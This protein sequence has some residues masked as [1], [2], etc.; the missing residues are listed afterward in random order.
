MKKLKRY[1]Q[2]T[3]AAKA[4]MDV[5]TAR[6]YIK[7]KMLPSDSRKA[8]H[9]EQP[10]IFAGHWDEIARMLEASP[11]LQSHTIMNYLVRKYPDR[12]K[13]SQ[14]R[15]LQ[16]HLHDWR[17]EYGASQAV[18]FRQDILPGKQ[19]QSDYTCMNALNIRINGQ[20]FKHLLFHFMLP[21]SRWESVYLCFSE[22]FETLTLGYEKAVW[23]LG[24]TAPEHRTDNLTAATHAYGGHREFTARW[25]EFMDH[26]SVMP[27]TNNIGVSHE[28]GSIEKSHDTLKNAIEQELMLRD[29]ADFVTQKDYMTFI[30]KIVA[31]RNLQRQDRLLAEMDYLIELPD[32]KWHSPT[33]MR[34][35]VSSGSIVQV[36]DVPY[37]VP[38]RLI[39]YT[40]KAYIYPDEIILFYGNKKIQTMPRARHHLDGI[41]YRHLID[42]LVRKPAAFANYQYHEALFPRLCFRKAYD[43]LQEN[44]PLNADRQ[45]LKLLQLAKLHSEQSVAEAL[46]ILLEERHVPAPESVKELMDACAKVPLD[47]H[48]Y[49]PSAADYDC[50]LS[51]TFGQGVH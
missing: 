26:Y 44:A 25:R 21:Y 29:N 24:C 14:L 47:V 49:Q 1:N 39:H 12:Y 46:D 38:S 27:T 32:K 23:E 50:L 30:E 8:Y 6:K 17:A 34:V 40:L 2:E 10:S 43:V 13:S 16:R 22:S 42:S 5:K 9:R 20:E 51:S 7:S 3:A 45:Y 28:N 37:T 4:G 15:T 31:G 36:L 18:I 41:N 11:G 19:S 35:R 48:V 33:V